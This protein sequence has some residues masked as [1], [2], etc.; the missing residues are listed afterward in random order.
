MLIQAFSSI[1]IGFVISMIYSWRL[2]LVML[3]LSPFII[4]GGVFEAKL[5]SGFTAN[6]EEAYKESSALVSEAVTNYR[7]V[8]SFANENRMLRFYSNTLSRPYKEGVK[9]AHLSGLFWGISQLALWII[10]GVSFYL[11]A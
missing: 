6:I 3:A 4:I 5:S 1:A 2:G 9:R 11:A 8:M 7:T 10:Y